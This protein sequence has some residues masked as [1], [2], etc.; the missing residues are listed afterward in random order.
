MQ[1]RNWF[2]TSNF[3]GERNRPHNRPLRPHQRRMPKAVV[4]KRGRDEVEQ[5]W[6]V[7]LE[8]VYSSNRELVLSQQKL[9]VEVSELKE[10]I[11]TLR[12]T[13]SPLKFT[14]GVPPKSRK[15]TAS[16]SPA[17]SSASQSFSPEASGEEEEL[18]EEDDNDEE[19]YVA[20]D[21]QAESYAAIQGGPQKKNKVWRLDEE[22]YLLKLYFQFYKAGQRMEWKKVSEHDAGEDGYGW[23][24]GMSPQRLKDKVGSLKDQRGLA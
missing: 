20:A 11:D 21:S 8:D 7:K 2:G 19:G 9:I 13:F 12:C 24:I 3:V 6:V 18:E 17:P 4:S 14:K 15:M 10:A 1:R 5:D 16:Q 23:F 22:N